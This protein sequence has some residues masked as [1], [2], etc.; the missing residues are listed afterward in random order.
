MSKKPSFK[1]YSHHDHF[2]DG[3][4]AKIVEMRMRGKTWEQIRKHFSTHYGI[5]RVRSTFQQVYKDYGH[6][7]EMGDTRQRVEILR[8]SARVKKLNSRHAKQNREILNYMNQQKALMEEITAHFDG[9][10]IKSPKVSERST[11]K[12]KR[13]MTMEV[14]YTDVHM[15]KKVDGFD[16][17]VCIKRTK[18]FASTILEEYE[19]YNQ[20]YNVEK[21]ILYLGGDNIENANIHG[22]ESTK[23]CEA[24]T[25]VQVVWYVDCVLHHLISPLALLGIPIDI[26]AVT[27]NHDRQG[28]K[29]TYHYPG[30]DSEAHIMY[31]TLKLICER[32]GWEHVSWDIPKGSYS[33]KNVYGNWI[34][35]E[36]GDE[37][38]GKSRSA[39]L[40]HLQKR[41]QQV[42]KLLSGIRMGHYHEYTCIDEGA[43][44]MNA[45]VC[46]QDSYADVK[47]FNTKPGQVINY[48]VKTSA[49][50][51]SFYHSFL[52]Q[53]D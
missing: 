23:G 37:V 1:K 4:L 6:L 9:I 51:S 33:I 44:I 31:H 8:E 14:M 45:S 18:Q 11:D 22:V 34:L 38:M 29:K 53:L 28:E 20:L 36:H 10:E 47:G 27:G 2:S 35:Y 30:Q 15:G 21:I 50:K 25:P 19:R 49:R 41:G 12:T 43:A 42:G 5:E 26:V 48:Y 13:E 3:H 7:Y 32:S 24:P 39:L 40:T 16:R 46:G 17:A 52:V